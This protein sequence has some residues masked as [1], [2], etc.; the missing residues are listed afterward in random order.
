[1]VAGEAVILRPVIWFI[2]AAN[3]PLWT[4]SAQSDDSSIKAVDEFF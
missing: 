4:L 3:L 2:V 1:M